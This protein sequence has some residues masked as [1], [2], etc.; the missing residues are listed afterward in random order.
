MRDE[1]NAQ[2]VLKNPESNLPNV[3]QSTLPHI[4]SIIKAFNLPRE[5]IASNEEIT[6][7]WKD[8]PREIQRI[9]PEL[10]MNLSPG[11]V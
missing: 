3:L 7:A 10:R 5:I 2:I 11:C 9:P 1:N 6:Y 8:L 4:E